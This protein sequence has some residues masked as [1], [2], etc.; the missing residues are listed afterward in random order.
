MRA[1]KIFT[2]LTI[3]LLIL[4]WVYAAVSKLLDYNA[5]TI[6][7]G[8]S[9]LLTSFASTLAILVPVIE[10]IIAVLLLRK[11]TA[12]A[13]LYCSLFLLVLFTCYLFAILNFSTS[14]PCSCGGIIGRFS[15]YTHILFNLFFIAINFVE[16]LMQQ[17]R[18]APT[19]LTKNLRIS[20][21]ST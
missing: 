4:L 2:E 18:P 14:V 19:D 21:G 17:K 5:F 20:S 16:I 7:L 6:Q 9:P 12:V 11:R 1:Q 8:Q 13:G 15:W 3:F 10:L